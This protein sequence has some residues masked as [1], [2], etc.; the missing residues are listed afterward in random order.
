MTIEESR[1]LDLET[2]LLSAYDCLLNNDI[3][4]AKEILKHQI[5][6]TYDEI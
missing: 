4:P 6:K 3:E 2:A 5:E 1:L